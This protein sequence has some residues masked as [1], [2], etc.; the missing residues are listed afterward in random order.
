MIEE[1]DIN[2]ADIE[3]RLEQLDR[4]WE[5]L[6]QMANNRYT[7]INKSNFTV[8]P[9]LIGHLYITNHCL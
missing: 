8:N 7:Q 4:S 1:S 3:A 9:V 2:T 6:K 5:E